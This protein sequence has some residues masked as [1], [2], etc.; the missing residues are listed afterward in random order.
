MC[1]RVRSDN[2]DA[3][4]AQWAVFAGSI[5]WHPLIM[6]RIEVQRLAS[7]DPLLVFGAAAN[8]ADHLA[9]CNECGKPVYHR[10]ES[11]HVCSQ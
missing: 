2:V 7:S 10:G 8:P 9:A 5:E 6:T 1:A 4:A 11:I 3:I